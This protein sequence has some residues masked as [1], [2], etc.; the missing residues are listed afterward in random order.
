MARDS[1][2][3]G[4]VQFVVPPDPVDARLLAVL[5]ESG[6]AAVHE[7]AQRLGMDPRA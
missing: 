4:S 7:I 3:A 5:A 6:R 2:A 1:G